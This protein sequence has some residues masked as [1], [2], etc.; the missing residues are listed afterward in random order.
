MA[1]FPCTKAINRVLANDNKNSANILQ[2]E[3]CG[4]NGPDDYKL[5][6]WKNATNDK[7]VSSLLYNY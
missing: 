7:D 1:Y 6:A 2:A 3:C 5:S 4:S